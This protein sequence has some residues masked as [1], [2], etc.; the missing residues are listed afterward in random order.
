MDKTII[1]RIKY[2]PK[3]IVG[4][5]KDSGRVTARNLMEKLG[6]TM[7]DVFCIISD[8]VKANIIVGE[9]KAIPVIS[10]V[11]YRIITEYRLT[12]FGLEIKDSLRPKTIS[13][14]NVSEMN[15]SE[16]T[17]VLENPDK[18]LGIMRS[19]TDEEERETIKRAEEN[20]N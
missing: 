8:L 16:F 15:A 6:Y 20:K 10:N 7:P 11:K 4:Y 9:M 1:K 3:R 14:I 12:D 17:E 2:D 13:L 5:I 19:V 18:P